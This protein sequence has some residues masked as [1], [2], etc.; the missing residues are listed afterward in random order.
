[1]ESQGT[2]G[3]AA[4]PHLDSIECLVADTED[5]AGNG[6]G[7][8]PD[9]EGGSVTSEDESSDLLSSGAA[10]SQAHELVR[11]LAE[12]DGADQTSEYGLPI[13]LVSLHAPAAFP[14]Y[15]IY[16]GGGEHF[17]TKRKETPRMAR[18]SSADIDYVWENGRR[19]CGEY[20]MPNDPAEQE[21]LLLLHTVYMGM[22]DGELT[23]APLDNPTHIL[24]VGAGTGEWVEDMADLYKDCEVTGIDIANVFP[25]SVHP[26]VFFEIDDAEMHWER[27]N[28]HYDLIHFRN[29]VGAFRD[30]S[31]VYEQA[32]R[33]AKPGGWIEVLDMNEYEGFGNFFSNFEPASV[34]HRAGRDLLQGS[35]MSG[36]PRNVAHL[37]PRL[38]YDAGF[39]DIRVTDHALPLSPREMSTGYLCL[40]SVA[41]GMEATA[42]RIL[43]RYMGWTAEEV[44][45]VSE[46]I[47]SEMLSIIYN[48]E[49][50]KGFIIKVRVITAR[51]PETTPR[52]SPWNPGSEV[53]ALEVDEEVQPIE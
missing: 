18:R 12:D 27:P 3:E 17:T 9:L 1:M 15:S 41:E 40:H 45:R 51:K 38:L 16:H 44:R 14:A 31:A 7:D 10:S 19:Y 26:N 52:P 4:P 47:R 36:R 23:T 21:R 53:Q 50:A 5:A 35:L 33:V 39:V 43:T 28:D 34:I 13:D 42:M 46:A 48:Y 29:M 30:W 32:F 24:D 6:P 8:L 11:S 22:F 49:K 20:F 25:K 2:R 37:E